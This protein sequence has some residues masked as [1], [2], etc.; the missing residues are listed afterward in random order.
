[1]QLSTCFPTEELYAGY[2]T[3]G[4]HKHMGYIHAGNQ[5][6]EYACLTSGRRKATVIAETFSELYSLTRAN[7]LQVMRNWPEYSKEMIQRV[8]R[9]S[10]VLKGR[11]GVKRTGAFLHNCQITLSCACNLLLKVLT[12]LI[13]RIPPY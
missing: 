3:D 8:L 5:F 11:A 10:R 9:Q 4:A 13:G 2:S 1:M 7:L 12:A 6:G